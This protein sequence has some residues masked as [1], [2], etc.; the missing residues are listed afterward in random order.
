MIVHDIDQVQGLKGMKNVSS[1]GKNYK[2]RE[3][4]HNV[5]MKV[6][7]LLTAHVELDR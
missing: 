3:S 4:Y 2:S 6:K 1:A 5:A 7:H